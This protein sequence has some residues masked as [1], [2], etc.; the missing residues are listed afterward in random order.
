MV[1]RH[2][3]VGC[4]SGELLRLAATS[5][6]TA[7]PAGPRPET[8]TGK[9]PAAR[10][11]LS[12]SGTAGAG[13]PRAHGSAPAGRA[14]ARPPTAPQS[15]RRTGRAGAD[16]VVPARIRL[17]A[18]CGPCERGAIGGSGTDAGVLPGATGESERRRRR[19]RVGERA[20]HASAAAGDASSGPGSASSPHA[21]FCPRL[22]AAPLPRPSFRRASLRRLSGGTVLS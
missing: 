15:P 2:S 6:Q 11:G 22:T 17:G 1:T 5:P 4:P 18:S 19:R 21:P 13:R 10:S 12:P 7:V 8:V 9:R 14:P 3:Q 16:V 20:V